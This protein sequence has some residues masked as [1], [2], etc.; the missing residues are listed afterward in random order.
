MEYMFILLIVLAIAAIIDIRTRRIPNWLTYPTMA[1]GLSYHVYTAGLQGF[2]FG[3]EGLILGFAL[4]VVFYLLGGMGA[5]DVKLMAGVGSVLG[6]KVVFVAFLFTALAGGIYAIVI[7][8]IHGKLK[9]YLLTIKNL[10][11]MRKSVIVPSE[12]KEK[13]PVLCY[14]VAIAVGTFIAVILY[15]YDCLSCV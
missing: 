3:L 7:L 12:D 2:L 9:N 15:R 6:P 1:V 4:L 13:L 11:L 5:G 8:M 14:G 10:I